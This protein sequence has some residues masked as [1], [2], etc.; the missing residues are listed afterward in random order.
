M[1]APLFPHGGVSTWGSRVMSPWAR[2]IRSMLGTGAFVL[3]T[4]AAIAAVRALW[5]DFSSTPWWWWPGYC[6]FGLSVWWGVWITVHFCG[7]ATLWVYTRGL[8]AWWAR[9]R[10]LH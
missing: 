3:T 8:R 10:G 9:L 7:W 5:S 2:R 4:S 6:M 1:S